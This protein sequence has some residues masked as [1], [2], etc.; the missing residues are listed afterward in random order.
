MAKEEFVAPLPL[1]KCINRLQ[2]QHEK[3]NWFS[4]NWQMRTVVRIKKDRRDP[5][6]YRFK[7]KRIGRNDWGWEF[8]L[9]AVEGTLRPMNEDQTLVMV[10]E[11]ISMVAIFLLS[12]MFG[13]GMGLS[14]TG[15][16][17]FENP[18]V[19]MQDYG[20]FVLV[21]VGLTAL[22]LLFQWLWLEHQI[23]LLGGIVY[24]VL[25]YHPQNA[26]QQK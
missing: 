21:S 26:I 15:S 25:G 12:V 4:W 10:E 16:L 1:P 8:A 2:E 9:A 5:M 24:D 14:F 20:L 23:K 18:D 11:R 13:V 22:I 17:L 7:L 3:M 6:V 19:S